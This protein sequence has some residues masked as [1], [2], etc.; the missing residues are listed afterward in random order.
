M[1][2]IHDAINIAASAETPLCRTNALA[3]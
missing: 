3:Y 1:P 2:D